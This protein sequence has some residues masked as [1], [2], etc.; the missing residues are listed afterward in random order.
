MS[1]L[2]EIR[3]GERVQTRRTRRAFCQPRTQDSWKEP[4]RARY[5]AAT[6]ALPVAFALGTAPP[7]D[8]NDLS[9]KVAAVLAAHREWI[10][11]DGA[12]GTR[13][14]FRGARLRGASLRGA[15]LN[16][17][18]LEDADL[19]GANLRGADFQGANLAGA[20]LAGANL[21]GARLTDASL[22]EAILSGADL[23]RAHLVAADLSGADLHRAVL[24]D[25]DLSRARLNGT[26]LSNAQLQG[27]NLIHADLEHADLAGAR[28]TSALLHAS[29]FSYANLASAR[30]EGA[31]LTETRLANA[32]LRLSRLR[33]A[34]IQL[35]YMTGARLDDADISG[36]R[37]EPSS[38]PDPLSLATVRGLGE[39]ILDNHTGL[40][41]WRSALRSVGLREQERVATWLIER[42]K[43]ARAGP[44]ESRARW[45]LFDATAGYGR[46]PLRPLS[47]VGCGVFLFAF[48]YAIPLLGLGSG[49]IL[50][51]WPSDSIRLS[52][53]GTI[54][55]TRQTRVERLR[56]KG[57][58]VTAYA[59]YFSLLSA[60]HIGWRE[61]NIGSWLH[62]LQPS[63]YAL[64]GAGW[65]RVLSGCQ[66]LISVYLIALSILTYFSNPFG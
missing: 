9:P 48:A 62:R 47:V 22:I 45:L 2:P 27:A 17:A 46:H 1:I 16:R 29:N 28:L 12:E 63:P 50:R 37:L 15:V 60:F 54:S 56:L 24:R 23:T 32:D 41:L 6:F 49:C 38:A 7:S 57:W 66:S 53:L 33:G 52:P 30:L 36:A 18:L 44:I 25:V 39:V 5:I 51:I 42:A 55:I 31:N 11:S 20:N 40:V 58:R 8:A 61:L 65:V 34:V 4:K 14:D 59:L 35:T 13:A 21:S 64:R 43:S 3:A 10:D 19:R 26:R